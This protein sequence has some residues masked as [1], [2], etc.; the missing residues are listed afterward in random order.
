[1]KSKKGIILSNLGS[2]S[3]PTP[4]ALKV[5]LDQFLMDPYVID[6][7]FWLRAIVVRGIILRTR[8]KKSA[9]AYEVIWTD[10]GSPLVST[11]HK[12]TQKIQDIL[13]DDYSVKFAMRYGDPSFKQV[14]QAFAKEKVEDIRVLPLYPQW[15]LASTASTLAHI[16]S[17]ALRNQTPSHL[18]IKKILK[19]FFDV[20]EFV[21]L[22][23]SNFMAANFTTHDK[24][25][26]HYLFSFHGIPE[27]HIK[28]TPGCNNCRFSDDCCL[29]PDAPPLCYR[30]NCVKTAQ[31]VANAI[32]LKPKEFT[33]SF[34]SRL[35]VDKWL[36]PPTD[37]V[38]EE[39]PKNGVERLIVFSPSFT[40]D[41]LE[42]IEELG[43]RGR[44]SFL[45]A[46]GKDFHLVPS[47]NSG[48]G[49]AALLAKWIKT[50]ELFVPV[51]RLTA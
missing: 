4:E 1:M 43:I 31:A 23:K 14:I 45:G 34:Q 51:E 7:P 19:N 11:T 33:V 37:K 50:E 9:E 12:L 35:G 8:P 20:P 30:S 42:T 2:P 10:E 41:C 6:L 32:G 15:A 17:K 25:T 18:Q 22:W 21:Q 40:A 44:E 46:G 38:L 47:L 27:R 36:Q 5:Y 48:D 49:W 29:A 26:T 16:Q 39:L 24:L 13:G 3:A 28:K